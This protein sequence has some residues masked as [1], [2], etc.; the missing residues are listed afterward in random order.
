M[1]FSDL[2]DQPYTEP[3]LI[4]IM[5]ERLFANFHNE[6]RYYWLKIEKVDE[7]RSK[8]IWIK[9]FNER[10]DFNDFC[11]S[12]K[13]QQARIA[14]VRKKKHYS[15]ILSGFTMTG[16]TDVFVDR[17]EKL[18]TFKPLKNRESRLTPP[19]ELIEKGFANLAG[20]FR[21]KAKRSA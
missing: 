2:L 9:S 14:L 8:I 7:T 18:P 10:A 4:Q 12:F 11:F 6:S 21:T 13:Y 20:Q 1:N 19:R 17:I 5:A 3:D 15:V 16:F